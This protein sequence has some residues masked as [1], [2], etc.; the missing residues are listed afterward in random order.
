MRSGRVT[1][2]SEQSSGTPN[3]AETG[4]GEWERDSG[5][6]IGDKGVRSKGQRERLG[7]KESAETSLLFLV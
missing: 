7:A 3:G 1:D 6:W 4:P 5:K 2:V